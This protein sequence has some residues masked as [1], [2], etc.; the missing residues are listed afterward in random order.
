MVK[1]ITIDRYLKQGNEE[2]VSEE[3][4]V[5]E[6]GP[7]DFNKYMEAVKQHKKKKERQESILRLINIV[8]LSMIGLTTISGLFHVF[9]P[10]F[11][12]LV[13]ILVTFA[14]C[15]LLLFVINKQLKTMMD[16]L[17][18]RGSIGILIFSICLTLL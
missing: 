1:S 5:S 14:M 8:M 9:I 12:F 2:N 17:P 13:V 6:D 10:I 3:A 15:I 7:F 18:N 4:R 16:M 11:T